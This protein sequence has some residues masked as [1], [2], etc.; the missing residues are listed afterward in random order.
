MPE[1]KESDWKLM[2][3]RLPKWQEAYMERLTREYIALLSAPG[4]ASDKFWALEK[5]LR[6]DKRRAGVVVANMRRSNM[7]MTLLTLLSEGAITADDLDGFST[8]LRR[9]IAECNF[10]FKTTSE[11]AFDRQVL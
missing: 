5:R 2:R 8:E 10:A 9:W 1:V 7:H 4:L 3:S 11:C 6:A